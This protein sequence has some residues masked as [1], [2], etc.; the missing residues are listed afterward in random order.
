MNA[1]EFSELL[2]QV[3]SG[4]D[5]N[6]P[7]VTFR[8][9]QHTGKIHL[10]P[11][12]KTSNGCSIREESYCSR[13]TKNPVKTKDTESLPSMNLSSLS[14]KSINESIN[15]GSFMCKKKNV[16]RVI[17][18]LLQNNGYDVCGVCVSHLYH[19]EKS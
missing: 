13:E 2:E 15:I 10:F 7:L 5:E 4:D 12:K 19:K 8:K 17:A 9:H 3:L 14:R 16:A 18:A 11:S 1:E 6:Y